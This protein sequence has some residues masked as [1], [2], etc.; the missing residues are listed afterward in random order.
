MYI[1]SILLLYCYRDL[2]FSNTVCSDINNHDAEN[3]AVETMTSEINMY[4]SILGSLPCMLVALFI[5]PW[6]DKNGRK[7]VMMIPMIGYILSTMWYLLNIHYIHWPATYLLASGVTQIFG[8]FVVFLIGMYSYMADITSIRARTT[9]IGVLDIFLFA[10]V[11]TGTFLSAYV[12]KYTGY[13][14]IYGT[15]LGVQIFVFAYIAIFIQDTRGPNSDFCYPNSEMDME[16]RSTFRRFISIFNIHQLVD[17]FK[18][19]FKRREYGIRS[20]ILTL[21]LLMLIN[22]TI[23]SDGGVLYLY[24]RKEFHW[25]EQMFTKFQTCSIGIMI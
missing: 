9:R 18:V 2:G 14:G 16:N 19:T 13:Y 10:G 1:N 12:Y 5:G 22:V 15:I 3:D 7:P 6:S 4:S 24:A 8:G 20:V 21:L 17:V 25:D 23:F 11:P